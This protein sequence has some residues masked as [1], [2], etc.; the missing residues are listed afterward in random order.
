GNVQCGQVARAGPT[1]VTCV[2]APSPQPGTFALTVTNPDG[3][4][5]TVQNGFSYDLGGRYVESGQRLP[6]EA[7]DQKRSILLVDID[8]D[9]DLDLFQMSWMSS[10]SRA[11][12]SLAINDGTGRFIPATQNLPTEPQYWPYPVPQY[13]QVEFAD[14]DKD[15]DTDILYLNDR[16]IVLY[17]NDGAGRYTRQD[18]PLCPDSGN[19]IGQNTQAR[20][21]TLGDLDGDG[22]LDIAVARLSNGITCWDTWRTPAANVGRNGDLI[23]INDGAGN[24]RNRYDGIPQIGDDSM[25]VVIADFDRDGDNDLLYVNETNHQNRLYYNQGNT[26]GLPVFADVSLS[27]LGVSGGNGQ[28]VAVGDVDGDGDRDIVIGNNGQRNRLY[29]NDGFGKFTDVTLTARMPA[30]IDNTYNVWLRDIDNDGDLDM[31][32]RRAPTT[33]A[34]LPMRIYRNDGTGFFA[35]DAAPTILPRDIGE[36]LY[37]VTFGDV[38]KDGYLDMVW[39]QE[40]FQNRLLLNDTNGKFVRNTITN[41]PEDNLPTEDAVAVDVDGDGDLDIAMCGYWFTW[42][43]WF[44]M[45]PRLYLND[46][47]GNFV[48]YTDARM[49]NIVPSCWDID[50]ADIDGDGDMDLFVSSVHNPGT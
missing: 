12:N 33:A 23:M 26:N 16:Q 18:Y 45:R 36:N 42:P 34:P 48:D 3:Q 1:S 28:Q 21:F 7:S 50:A 40:G 29:I 30:D 4:Q 15:L 6:L 20:G 46:G 11:T 35:A 10:G 39:M 14:V 2:T 19:G 17:R 25:S 37:S 5:V 22:D 24:F 44:G 41:F 8:K 49:P 43:N 47:A 31:L 32:T 27:L 13:H 9:N 38:N